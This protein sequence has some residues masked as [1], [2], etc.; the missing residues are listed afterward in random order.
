[1]NKEEKKNLVIKQ[2]QIYNL[3]CFFCVKMKNYAIIKIEVLD[4]WRKRVE[5]EN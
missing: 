5:K 4:R 1:M 3:I 2:M